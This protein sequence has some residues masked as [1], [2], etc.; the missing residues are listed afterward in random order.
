MIDGLKD[1][2]FRMFLA[3]CAIACLVGFMV[4]SENGEGWLQVLFGLM[5]VNFMGVHGLKK[6]VDLEHLEN[7]NTTKY[8]Q[9]V[10]PLDSIVPTIRDNN[11]NMEH[12]RKGRDSQSN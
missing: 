4:A 1:F 3:V 12:S 11:D 9:M 6:T 8:I 10:E 7:I 2:I 5:A